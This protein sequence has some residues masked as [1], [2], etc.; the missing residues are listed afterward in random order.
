MCLGI[1][2]K[3]T[4]TNREHD[5]LMGKVD[6]GGVSKQICLDLT[7]DVQV[8]QY[9]IVH[10]GF[11][12]QVIDEDEAEQIFEFLRQMD[13]LDELEAADPDPSAESVP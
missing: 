7:P 5:M 2:G 8:D 4:E 1:P 3:V 13:D 11:A 9:V 12:L 6:F 10:V